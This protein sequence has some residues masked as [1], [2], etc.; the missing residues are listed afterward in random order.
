M[1]HGE[2]LRR[3]PRRHG[4]PPSVSRT[5]DDTRRSATT[6]VYRD[7]LALWAIPAVAIAALLVWLLGRPQSRW[8]SGHTALQS[9]TVGGLDLGKQVTDSIGTLRSSLAG[10]TDAASAQAALPK[11]RPPQ[12][13]STK[14]TA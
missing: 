1:Q 6:S 12:R 10:I 2:Q 4:L 13:R 7:E 5:I 9:L 14:W 11:L 8:S 3:V